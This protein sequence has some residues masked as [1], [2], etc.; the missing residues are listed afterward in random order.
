VALSTRFSALSAFDF[1]ESGLFIFLLSYQ[2]CKSIDM[3][4][5]KFMEQQPLDPKLMT[6]PDCGE[7]ERIGVHS[8]QERRCICHACR[9]TFA[10]TKGTV[11]FNLH[12]PIWVVVLVL[13]LLGHG[14][15]QQP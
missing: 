9:V 6:C 10:E 11:F 12:Y 2:N 1:S 7:E 15:P 5:L 14:C 3:A 13:T 8:H 4:T